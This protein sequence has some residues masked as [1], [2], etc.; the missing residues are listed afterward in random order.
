MAKDIE[1]FDRNLS[2]L[3]NLFITEIAKHTLDRKVLRGPFHKLGRNV[4]FAS[5]K[6][7]ALPLYSWAA[8]TIGSA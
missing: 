5:W 2:S 6:D 3:K 8:L 7:H 4:A 1:E